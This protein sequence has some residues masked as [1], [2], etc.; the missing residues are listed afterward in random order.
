M[1]YVHLMQIKHSNN[2]INRNKTDSLTRAP[3]TNHKFGN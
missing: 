2:L 3:E 1:L